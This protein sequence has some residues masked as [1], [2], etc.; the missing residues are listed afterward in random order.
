MD[1][2]AGCHGVRD[3]ALRHRQKYTVIH[4]LPTT[5]AWWSQLSLRYWCTNMMVTRVVTFVHTNK[6][7]KKKKKKQVEKDRVQ[8]AHKS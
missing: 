5:L 2:E 7:K 1:V 6:K 4:R 3:G 8:A